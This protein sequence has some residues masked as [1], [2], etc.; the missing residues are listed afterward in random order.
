MEKRKT[1]NGLRFV[2]HPSTIYE[3]VWNKFHPKKMQTLPC[4][5]V[6]ALHQ[7]SKIKS[8][9]LL[10]FFFFLSKIKSKRILLFFLLIYIFGMYYR[11]FFFFF[12]IVRR[13]QGRHKIFLLGDI[14]CNKFCI[15]IGDEELVSPIF[16]FCQAYFYEEYYIS[17]Y[18]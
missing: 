11:D 1:E 17:K 18:L 2:L 15:F 8:K 4:W 7:F 12:T 10:L 3:G 13:K 6:I 9:S 14:R 5:Q 16:L